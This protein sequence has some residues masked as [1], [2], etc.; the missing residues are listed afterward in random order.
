MHDDVPPLSESSID[1]DKSGIFEMERKGKTPVLRVFLVILLAILPVVAL[2]DFLSA[3]YTVFFGELAVIATVAGSLLLLRKGH[4]IAA[5]R[6]ASALFYVGTFLSPFR[7][8][9]P[10]PRG[11][12]PR[13]L[14]VRG[15]GIRELFPHREQRSPFHGGFQ[16]GRRH[17]LSP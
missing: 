17:R 2:T 3:D 5:S 9:L 11:F 13:R 15:F 4:Y 6:I 12:R 1:G 8:P 16:Y 10:C 7:I 14:Y